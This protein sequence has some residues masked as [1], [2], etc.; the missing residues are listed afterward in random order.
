MDSVFS[1][2]VIT[3][4]AWYGGYRFLVK[5]VTEDEARKERNRAEWDEHGW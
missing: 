1:W 5:I 3:F 2:I 4:G